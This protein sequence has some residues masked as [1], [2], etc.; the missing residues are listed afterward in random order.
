[1][2]NEDRPHGGV[3]LDAGF[4]GGPRVPQPASVSAD[5]AFR[6]LIVGDFGGSG[7]GRLVDVSGDDLTTLL[8]SFG[9][10]VEVDAPNR[11]G[12]V[13]PALAV[14]LP[15][16]SVRDLDPKTIP[17]RIPEIV[18]AERLKDR[19]QDMRSADLPHLPAPPSL[20]HV[21]AA[22]ESARA[23]SLRPSPATPGGGASASVDS[24]DGSIDRLLDMIDAPTPAARPDIAKAAISAFVSSS[25]RAQKPASAPQAAA[26][27][28]VRQAQDVSTHPRWL[29]LEASWRSLRLIL[30]AR[31]SRG[32]TRIELCDMRRAAMADCVE[33]EAFG[34]A[35]AGL[36]LKAILVLG[37]FGP[38]V[39]D[40]D[41]LDR[42]AR[43]AEGLAIPMIVSLDKDFFGAPPESVAI[44]DNP[45]ALL[46]GQGYASWRGLRGRNE[47]RWLFACWNDFVLRSDATSAP[48]LWGEPGA[49]VAAQ[50]LRS[51]TRTGWPTEIVGVET[52]LGGLEVVE[53]EMRVGRHS[54]IPLRALIDPGVAR[55]LGRE[56][57]ICLAC[58]SDRDRAW[59]VR[60]PHLRAHGATLEADREAM[61]NFDS[62][63]FQ[64]VS[65]YFENLLRGAAANLRGSDDAQVCASISR[66]VNDALAATGPGASAHARPA[67]HSAQDDD[68][69]RRFE[70]S[71][72]L[73]RSVMGG[74]AFSFDVA[75]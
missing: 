54:A 11:L 5:V 30:A 66:L 67:A 35:A 48:V 28:L 65:T 13:P 49:I 21:F 52:A 6:L 2:P 24:D 14:R 7:D 42:L 39:K 25:G 71:V 37:A 1:M 33:S 58:R 8:A 12:S 56:G 20:D 43:A 69:A 72:Q 10:V 73:G 17:A 50:I 59:L 63:P 15:I 47:S 38:S 41:A 61:E 16:T 46:E 75:L 23:A 70:V 27:L 36:Q 26:Q 4:A 60:A 34:E 31:N 57:I 29:G 3:H 18:E 22:L 45:G 55:D 19:F 68:S 64:F 74:F 32:A 62:L 53:V 40:L 9:A 51:L 44:M